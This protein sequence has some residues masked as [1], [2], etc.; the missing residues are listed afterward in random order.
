MKRASTDS[1]H[2]AMESELRLDRL[3]GRQ[4]RTANNQRVGRLE[5]CRADKDGR[6][7]AITEYVIGAAGLFE[8][9]GVGVKLLLGRR[10]GGYVARWDQLDISDPER[11]RL[12]CGVEELQRL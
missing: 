4:V 8:R 7:S 6:E 2:D 10:V 1:A 3:L 5:E 12:T 9:L 11:P